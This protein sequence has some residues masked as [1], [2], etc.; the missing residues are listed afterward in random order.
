MDNALKIAAF[1]DEDTHIL[2]HIAPLCFILDI[3]MY[4]GDETTYL[5]A[6]KY[7]PQVNIN[8]CKNVFNF[9]TKNFQTLIS[10]KLWHPSLFLIHEKIKFIFCPHGNS[11]K[12][13]INK[14]LLQAYAFQ[15]GLFLYGNQQLDNLKKLNILKS[16][17]PYKKIGNF[18]YSFYL[19]QKAFYDDLAQKEIFS[20]INPKN[21]TI[22]YV[23]TWKDSENSTSF[24]S[25]CKKLIKT[26]PKDYNLI[27]KVHPLLEK[28]DPSLFYQTLPENLPSNVLILNTPLV[29]PILEKIDILLGDFSSIGYD[30]L[31]FEKPMFFID[32]L[33][34]NSKTSSLNL[35]KCGISIPKT[36]YNNIYS[37]I[38]KNLSWKK[39]L[40]QK[41]MFLYAFGKTLSLNE[42]KKRAI[43][44][45]CQ[46]QTAELRKQFLFH[47]D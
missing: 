3:P 47:L 21:K 39:S 10:C 7:Y 29:F 18:R 24:F 28:R 4:I 13:F 9:L 34:R 27:I 2:D 14:S 22:L 26:L 12:G 30:F 40:K 31:I 44:L 8:L 33:Q 37:F 32:H 25:I 11:D 42:L 1:A 23:P 46:S 45:S 6:K 19:N 16:L 35:H 20:K 38:E 15:G 5:I 36:H 17:P 43:L 41:K